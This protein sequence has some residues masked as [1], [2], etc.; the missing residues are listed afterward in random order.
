MSQTPP[1]G[2]DEIASRLTD[3][4]YAL[5]ECLPEEGKKVALRPMVATAKHARIRINELVGTGESLESSVIQTELKSLRHVGLAV[6]L[7]T[8]AG[9]TM[10]WQRTK[11]A[12]ELI[13]LHKGREAPSSD[14]PDD[15][16]EPDPPA[17]PDTRLSLADHQMFGSGN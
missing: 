1:H 14:D 12:S 5:L 9:S 3:L 7:T 2:S 16:M 15:R 17:R 8:L 13:A 11:L 4:H 10:G 6:R